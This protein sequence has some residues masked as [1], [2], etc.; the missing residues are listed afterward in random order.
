MTEA[1]MDVAP[2]MTFDPDITRCSDSCVM[3]QWLSFL[4]FALA[5]L[6]HI[7]FFVVE[8]ILYQKKGGHALFKV[9]EA[10]HQATKV[11]AFNQGFY[12]L[13]LALGTFGGLY[14][15]FQRQVMLA[16][17]LTGFCGLSMICAGIVLWYSAPHLRRGA[18]AQILP[19]LLGFIFLFFHVRSFQ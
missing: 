8:S 4:C 18:L 9:S 12:N 2:T 7:I 15:V 11:W 6:L 19:P 1:G 14:F 17:V 3:M 10:D 5:G 13:F 16:G